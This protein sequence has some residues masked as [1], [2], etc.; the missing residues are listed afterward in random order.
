MDIS[1]QGRVHSLSKT[2]EKVRVRDR[3]KMHLS[4]SCSNIIKII[5]F[6]KTN[7]QTKKPSTFTAHALTRNFTQE[8]RSISDKAPLQKPYC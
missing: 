1:E 3:N 5:N 6:L 2:T 8:R 7:N 4:E